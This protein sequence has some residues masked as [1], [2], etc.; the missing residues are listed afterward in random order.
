MAKYA[1]EMPFVTL[2]WLAGRSLLWLFGT[3]IAIDYPRPTMPNEINIGG[4]STKPGKSLSKELQRFMDTAEHG[5]VLASFG[6][7][8][9]MPKKDLQVLIDAFKQ[10]KQHV[11]ILF[12][13][14]STL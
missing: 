4:L 14:V 13:I 9:A 7:L 8:S 1:P 12:L 6:S 3:D 10:I 5:V 11:S 2:N